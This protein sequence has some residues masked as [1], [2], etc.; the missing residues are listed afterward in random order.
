M[1]KTIIYC[2]VGVIFFKSF[3]VSFNSYAQGV[4][5]TPGQ[6]APEF[7]LTDISSHQF[8]SR[9]FLQ[10][11]KWVVYYFFD[12]ESRVCREGLSFFSKMPK[13][14]HDNVKIVAITAN[15][16]D[17][18]KT[19][20][21]DTS[22]PILVLIDETEEVSSSYYSLSIFPKTYV[23][24]NAGTIVQ[25]VVGSDGSVHSVVTSLI[26]KHLLNNELDE[27]NELL[28]NEDLGKKAEESSTLRDRINA[29]L[30][31]SKVKADKFSDAINHFNEIKDPVLKNE[32]LAAVAYEKG[33]DK[34]AEEHINKILSTDGNKGYAHTLQAKIKFRKGDVKD[35]VTEYEKA[36]NDKASLPWQQAEAINNMGRALAKLDRPEEAMSQY[37]KSLSLYPEYVVPM[38]N[39]GVVLN[40]IGRYEDAGLVLGKASR[41]TPQNTV[42]TTLIDKNNED[43]AYSK[44]FEKQQY[45]QKM[46][47]KLV[48]RH[49][50]KQNEKAGVLSK[51][52]WTSPAL[53]VSLLP[54][55]IQENNPEFDGDSIILHKSIEDSLKNIKR[56]RLV[57]RQIIDKL[58]DELDIGSSELADKKQQLEL[59]KIL[60]ARVLLASDVLLGSDNQYYITMRSVETETSEILGSNNF[61]LSGLSEIS[62]LQNITSKTLSPLYSEK[63]PFRGKIVSVSGQEVIVNLG[64]ANGLYEGIVFQVIAQGEPVVFEGEVLG[65]KNQILADLEVV[66][67]REK[68]AITRIVEKKGE[69]KAGMKCKEKIM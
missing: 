31:Y 16:S 65:Y 38:S 29:T 22:P 10:Q 20:F 13:R 54:P 66:E 3:F 36:V 32:G 15:S 21:Q 47:R 60:A 34:K 11:E 18:L 25:V 53:T 68:M 1:R 9:S 61:N 23:V 57:E 52:K 64:T 51:E 35:S 56:V 59:G 48:Q 58:L 45:V 44:D 41:I 12:I 42:I 37:D 27:A 50:Q 69:L 26:D 46:V 49:K 28:N 67:V 4:E 6:S 62:K 39:K 40:R 5:L 14:V 30:G 63:F 7:S 55:Q 17:K 24:N 33:D 8:D 43:L 2:F 19:F